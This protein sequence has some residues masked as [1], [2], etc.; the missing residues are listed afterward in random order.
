MKRSTLS[1]HTYHRNLSSL[2]SPR[3]PQMWMQVVYKG[4]NK[5]RS[6]VRFVSSVRLSPPVDYLWT[7]T[8]LGSTHHHRMCGQTTASCGLNS[9]DYP[10]SPTTH[11]LT[12]ELHTHRPQPEPFVPGGNIGVVHTVHNTYDDDYLSQSPSKPH[13]LRTPTRG[14]LPY[15]S[16][17]AGTRDETRYLNKGVMQ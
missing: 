15:S 17:G 4:V 2:L 5:K 8:P 1:S 11:N 6:S 13:D 16:R 10:P 12:T 3:F 14:Y 7:E 9:N